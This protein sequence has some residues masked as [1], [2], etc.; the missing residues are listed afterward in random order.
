MLSP[1]W[2]ISCATTAPTSNIQR[3]DNRATRKGHTQRSPD[4]RTGV[5]PH[6]ANLEEVDTGIVLSCERCQSRWE[7]T[8]PVALA[9]L[10]SGYGVLCPGCRS[11]LMPQRQVVPHLRLL[12]ALTG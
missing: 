7:E 11:V 6:L 5:G 8:D 12:D 1:R 10:R 3:A 4:I 9:G 2:T